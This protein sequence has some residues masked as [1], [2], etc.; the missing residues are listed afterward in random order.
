MDE[1]IRLINTFLVHASTDF[2]SRGD[3]HDSSQSPLDPELDARSPAAGVAWLSVAR[4]PRSP[5]FTHWEPSIGG[6]WRVLTCAGPFR[7]G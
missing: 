1:A 4:Q 2:L 6:A 5:R 3:M 7:R